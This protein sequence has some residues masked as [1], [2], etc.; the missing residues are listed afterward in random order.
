MRS[1]SRIRP[2]G[3]TGVVQSMATSGV[4]LVALGLGVE[5]ELLL[6]EPRPTPYDQSHVAV[7]GEGIVS[8]D[9]GSE[10]QMPRAPPTAPTWRRR[11]PTRLARGAW[12]LFAGI[13]RDPASGTRRAKGGPSRRLHAAKDLW[14]VMAVVRECDRR[15][16]RRVSV[17]LRRN[18]LALDTVVNDFN[19]S[20]SIDKVDI[21]FDIDN[22]ASMGDK[23]AYL[24]AAIPQISST[25]S[26]TPVC[27][28]AC[29]YFAGAAVRRGHFA[30]RA[31]LTRVLR[32]STIMHLGS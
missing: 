14:A 18:D 24:G 28:S 4:P 31:S 19:W 1:P 9:M 21:L 30:R 8:V 32:R 26:S 10:W 20:C 17:A 13:W 25:G 16:R 5:L 22:S 12:A 2:P 7:R 6:P 11:L 15:R 29:R 27:A 23:Q 3:S